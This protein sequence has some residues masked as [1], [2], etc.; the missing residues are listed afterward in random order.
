MLD[1]ESRAVSSKSSTN[2]ASDAFTLSPYLIPQQNME[3]NQTAIPNEPPQ[4]PFSLDANVSVAHTDLMQETLP[5]YSSLSNTDV[6]N[7]STCG[8]IHSSIEKRSRTDIGPTNIRR[9]SL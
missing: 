7:V 8:S 4:T 3:A 2:H 6:S 5:Q 1:D 9:K